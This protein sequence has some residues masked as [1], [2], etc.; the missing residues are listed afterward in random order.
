MS[1][2]LVIGASLILAERRKSPKEASSAQIAKVLRQAKLVGV[3]CG[4]DVDNRTC[5]LFSNAL[6]VGLKSQRV[7]VGQFYQPETLVQSF[8]VPPML[9]PF[10]DVTVRLIEATGRDGAAR[11]YLGGSCFDANSQD[12]LGFQLPRWVEVESVRDTGPLESER[13]EAAS[14]LVKEFV[15]YWISTVK[16]KY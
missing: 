13:A 9:F 11:V 7:N 15:A 3:F 2:A 14:K 5:T 1:L 16:E 8:Y 6:R 12:G 10:T 4:D